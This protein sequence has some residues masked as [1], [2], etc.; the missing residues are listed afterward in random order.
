MKM[1]QLQQNGALITCPVANLHPQRLF[2]FIPHSSVPN[3]VSLGIL[4]HKFSPHSA[5]LGTKDIHLTSRETILC[6]C[7][8]LLSAINVS[9]N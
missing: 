9:S 1:N 4:C 3:S 7:F 6:E 5:T 8:Y 2:A